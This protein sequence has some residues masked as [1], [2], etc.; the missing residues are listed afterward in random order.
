[1]NTEF[2]PAGDQPNAIAELSAGVLSGERDQVLLG[3][4]GTGKTFTMAKIIEKPNALRLF[5]R[6]TK[7][8]PHSYTVSSKFFPDNAVEYFVAFMTITSPRPMCRV[9]TPTSKKKIP[10]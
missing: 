9:Q 3:A 5:W 8:W 1:M 6:Q 2:E 4:T 7:H 10:D